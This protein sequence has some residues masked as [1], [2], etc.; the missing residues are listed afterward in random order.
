MAMLRFL[1]AGE[2]HGRCLTGIVEGL[3][4][5]LPVDTALINHEL[6]RRQLGYGRGRRMRIETDCIEITAGVRHGK[7]LGSPVSFTVT[8]KDWDN[9]KVPMSTEPVP[10]DAAIRAVTR[11]RPGH[12]DLA[13][14]L[15]YQTHDARDVL[16]RASARETAARVAIGGLCRLL[17]MHFGIR[18]SSHVLAVGCERVTTEQADA[19]AILAI[20]PESPLRCADTDAERRMIALIDAAAKEGDTVGGIA[21]IIAA[22]VPPGLGSHTQWDVRLDG[23]LAQALMSIP[24]VKAVEIGEGIS[25]AQQ[26]GSA[27]HDEIFYDSGRRRFYRK[28]NRAGGLEAGMTNGSDL[29]A[30]IF[31]KP[32]PTLRKP[33]ISADLVTKQESPA[34]FE[35]SDT[36]V[37]P[38]AGVIGEAMLA[39][40]LA[41]S[42][43]EKFAGDSMRE[44]GANYE[45]YRK[46]LHDF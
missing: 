37:V 41:E 14:A 40:I 26:P 44:V 21:E 34:A 3:P 22:S 20:D 23:R 13:G 1:T 30:R 5:G 42:F 16:E 27:V 43:L 8:N 6:R 29:R 19:S 11:P 28:T 4:A 46:L 31:V 25:T 17:L 35:R 15:K 33:L 10:E 39:I 38:T 7:T 36:C 2:S 12:A 9:W 24:A 32:I 18:I 45:N